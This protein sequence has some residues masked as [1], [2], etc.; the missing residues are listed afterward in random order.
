[1]TNDESLKVTIRPTAYN[2][3]SSKYWGKKMVTQTSILSETSFKNENEINTFQ[4]QSEKIHHKQIY[5]KGNVQGCSNNRR[6]II[7]DET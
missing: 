7:T 2:K 4:T 6:K 5:S 1:M 3:R